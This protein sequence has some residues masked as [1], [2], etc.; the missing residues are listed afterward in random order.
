MVQTIIAYVLVALAAAWAARR[1]VLPPV[2]R[3]MAK[4][5]PAA[6]AKAKCDDCSCGD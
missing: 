2:R 6:L 5:D 1:Y 3:A 4:G